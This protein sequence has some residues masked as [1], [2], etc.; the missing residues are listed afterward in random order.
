MHALWDRD[1]C[2]KLKVHE[3]LY[4]FRRYP[5]LPLEN[6][7]PDGGCLRATKIPPPPIPRDHYSW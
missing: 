5:I 6:T 3:T 4:R 1:A 7:S 2:G